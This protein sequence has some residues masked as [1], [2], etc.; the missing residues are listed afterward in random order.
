MTSVTR[1]TGSHARRSMP[2]TTKR[3]RRGDGNGSGDSKSS[4]RRGADGCRRGRTVPVPPCRRSRRRWLTRHQPAALRQSP[5]AIS[6]Y[7]A[8]GAA[9]SRTSSRK[10]SLA[11]AAPMLLRKCTR[12]VVD[13]SYGPGAGSES[14]GHTDWDRCLRGCQILAWRWLSSVFP[15]VF[16]SCLMPFSTFF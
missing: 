15:R 11:G 8:S 12:G 5:P 13:L 2:P 16:K 6:G 4:S 3:L 1:I 9:S 10:P 14:S 7:S